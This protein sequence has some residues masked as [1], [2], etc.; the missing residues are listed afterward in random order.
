MRPSVAHHE[1]MGHRLRC[2][3]AC[4]LTRDACPAPQQLAR[5]VAQYVI[6]GAGLDTFAERRPDVAA[7][8][9]VF[10]IDEPETQAWKQQ[11]LAAL[12]LA[13]PSSVR[14]VPVDFERGESWLARLPASAKLPSGSTLVMSF[15]LP[16]ELAEAQFR[17]GIEAAARGARTN[18]TPWVSFFTPDEM[19]ALAREAGFSR[20]EH[21]SCRRA[22]RALLRRAGRWA[23][24]A[25]QLR[26]APGRDDVGLPPRR[27][28]G[29]GAHGAHGPRAR[30]ALAREA[31]GDVVHPELEHAGTCG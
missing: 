2:G 13:H 16:I 19:L 8:L 5:G 27:E 15:M 9:R 11:R 28:P 3:R 22:D 17:P 1:T 12:G 14:F 30:E 21:V 24:A 6:L 4:T 7:R 18:R 31:R 20:V 10:E 23:S 29:V 25:E 26:G